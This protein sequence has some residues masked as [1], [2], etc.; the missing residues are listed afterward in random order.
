MNVENT[1]TGSEP[2]RHPWDHQTPG[3]KFT[4]QR[5]LILEKKSPWDLNTNSETPTHYA[6]V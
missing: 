3:L 2:K 4:N 5:T 6:T 1:V